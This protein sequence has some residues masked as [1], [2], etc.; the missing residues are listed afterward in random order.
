MAVKRKDPSL[1]GLVTLN[2]SAKPRQKYLEGIQGAFFTLVS[3]SNPA[4]FK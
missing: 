4:S 3:A 2:P 1:K